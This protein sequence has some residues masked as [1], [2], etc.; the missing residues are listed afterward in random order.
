M[1]QGQRGWFCGSVGREL[2]QF[3]VAEGGS[4]SDPKDAD[5]LF[6]C[7]ASHPDTLRIYQSLDYIE[8][9]ATVF[10]AYYLSAVANAEMKNSVALGHFILPPACLQEE[11]RRKVG[12]FI[13]EQDQHIQGEKHDEVISNEIKAL[14]ESSELATD[15]EKELSKST[16]KHF[17]RTPVTEK[18][19]Y[20]PLQN[21]PVNNMVT[22]YISIDAMKKFL[23][24][25]RDFIPGSSGYLAYH[26]QN[27]INMSAIKN[28]LKRKC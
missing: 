12:S 27:E 4:I 10:H 20:F 9:N 21:Y 26:V 11:I 22:G 3:W 23:G 16:E 5:F 15:Q 24:E 18:Q 17:I 13:W 7:D 2:R 6:S 14:R 25:L 1:F 28:K 8:D 19:M